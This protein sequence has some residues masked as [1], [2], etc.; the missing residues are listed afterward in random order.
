M[1]RLACC[2]LTVV[3]VGCSGSPGSGGPD[4]LADSGS[5]WD[6]VTPEPDVLGTDIPDDHR[7]AVTPETDALGT[8]IPDDPLDSVTPELDTPAIDMGAESSDEGCLPNCSGREC[9]DDGCGGQCGTCD[10]ASCDGLLWTPGAACEDGKC[11]V[12]QVRDCED[13]LNCTVDSCRPAEGCGNDLQDGFC[14]ID[15]VCREN[16]Q[17]ALANPCQACRTDVSVTSWSPV[18]NGSVCE[19][20]SCSASWWSAPRTCVDGACEGGGASMSCDDARA[21]TTDACVPALGC[22]HLPVVGWCLIDGECVPDGQGNPANPCELCSAVD[23]ALA[24]SFREDELECESRTC[25]D[26]EWMP[27]KVCRSGVCTASGDAEP[28]DD[29]KA[30]TVDACDAATGCSNQIR[31]EWCLIDGACLQAGVQH[32]EDD[33]L[34]CVPSASTTEWRWRAD[35]SICQT[36]KACFSGSC[37]A[38]VTPGHGYGHHGVCGSWNGCVDALGCA[39]L[40]CNLFNLGPPAHFSGGT[41]A[42]SGQICDIFRG[43]GTM[44]RDW[45][46]FGSCDLPIVYNVYCFEPEV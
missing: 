35:G 42:T 13:D 24:W 34:E 18:E 37:L 8:D 16:G 5:Q 29:G 7:D 28:C 40:V 33:C 11:A 26:L 4:V 14:L 10:A 31:P 3:L 30:C 45:K 9:G 32:P 19:A 1:R 20:G 41:C 12:V 2:V 46:P 25:E 22:T 21:C 23:E 39:V 17:A 38:V 36:D 27:T 15:G 6:S 44:E 43:D